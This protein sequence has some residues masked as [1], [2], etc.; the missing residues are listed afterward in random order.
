MSDP[1]RLMISSASEDVRDLLRQAR[2]SAPPGLKERAMSTALQALVGPAAPAAGAAAAKAG[3]AAKTSALTTVHWVGL[4]CL[5]GVCAAGGFLAS[6]AGRATAGDAPHGV[7]RTAVPFDHAPT[8]PPSSVA[9]QG[10]YPAPIQVASLPTVP[11]PPP[12]TTT[13]TASRFRTVIPAAAPPA[14]TEDEL[15]TGY[16]PPDPPP[17]AAPKLSPEIV[18]LDLTRKA[19]GEG[20]GV[21]ALTLLRDYDV[22]FPDGALRSEATMLRIEALMTVGRKD[23]AARLGRSVIDRDPDGPYVARIRSLLGEANP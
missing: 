5:V 14:S 13:P 18:L 1:A 11:E 15:G 12:P 10:W 2:S 8:A 22:R 19:L 7:E 21:R 4:A 16:A 9:S 20:Y 6:R 17:P 23:E 3:S